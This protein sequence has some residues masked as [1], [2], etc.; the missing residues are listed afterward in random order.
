MV[1]S[2]YNFGELVQFMNE[3]ADFFDHMIDVEEDKFDAIL[4]YDVKELEK[5]VA[6]QQA[7][8]LYLEKMEKRR[9]DVQSRAGVSGKTFSEII[10]LADGSQKEE[11]QELFERIQDAVD[12]IKYLNEKSMER[13]KENLN[14]LKDLGGAELPETAQTYGPGFVKKAES[15][16]SS[17][18]TFQ[19]KI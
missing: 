7:V 18:L 4:S 16:K 15:F 11:L 12:D 14:V 13:V 6:S 1:V 19:K 17:G 8:Q 5:S 9:E 2:M 10:A 3:Y